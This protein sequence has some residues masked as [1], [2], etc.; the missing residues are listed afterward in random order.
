MR[1]STA[2]SGIDTP[3]VAALQIANALNSVSEVA[4]L[5]INNVHAVETNEPCREEFIAAEEG[6]GIVEN[7]PRRAIPR[8]LQQCKR[9]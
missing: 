6:P 1:V 7:W 5:L 8:M 9:L 3:E 4:R 2:C